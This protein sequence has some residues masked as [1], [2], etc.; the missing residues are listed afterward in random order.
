MILNRKALK[1]PIL[2]NTRKPRILFDQDDVLADFLGAVVEKL[3]KKYNKNYSIE[4]CTSWNLVK[5]FGKESIEIINEKGFFYN[6]KPKKD[7]I[8]VLKRMYTSGK[9]DIRIV[10]ASMPNSYEEK[11]EWIKKYMPF[12]KEEHFISCKNKSSVWGDILI[13]DAEH[14]LIDFS[15]LGIS[16]IYDMPHNRHVKGFKRVYDLKEA[17]DYIENLFYPKNLKQ[18]I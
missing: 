10:T 3:N 17:E 5:N 2:L 13:D 1:V 16:I 11:L 4:Q 14:N 9:Y 8:E 18:V 6:L 12:F 15:K 7:A